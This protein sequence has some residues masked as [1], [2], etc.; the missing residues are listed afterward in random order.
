MNELCIQT[1]SNEDLDLLAVL[2]KQ[3]IED[4]QYDNQMNMEQLKERMQG[5]INTDYNAYLFKEKNEIKGYALIN[6]A[7]EPLYLRQFFICR[8]SRR[9][10]YGKTAF[11][12]LIDLLGTHQIDIEVMSWNER[13]HQFWKSLGFNERS[14]Y[15]RLED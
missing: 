15:M 5:F 7:R 3:L 11:T 13:G 6:H 10:G 1:C 12:K 2:N 4:E 9:Q 8:D 14:V